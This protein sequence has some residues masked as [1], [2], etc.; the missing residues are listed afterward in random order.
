MKKQDDVTFRE[1][2]RFHQIWVRALILLIA[3][4]MW[5]ITIK[6]IVFGIPMGDNPAPDVL[7]IIF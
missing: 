4:I 7:L 2:Q 5:Y 3:G 6:Q 1:V